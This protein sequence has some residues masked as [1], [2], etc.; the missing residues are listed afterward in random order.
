M[1]RIC[2]ACLEVTCRQLFS[3]VASIPERAPRPTRAEEPKPVRKASIIPGKAPDK[4]EPAPAVRPVFA[5]TRAQKL[6]D[7]LQAY[8]ADK[9]SP[10]EYHTERA[11]ILAEP[12]P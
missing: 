5:G 4:T 10:I 12:N 1:A 7:L 6:A 8:K 11:K 9:I 3:S 2:C